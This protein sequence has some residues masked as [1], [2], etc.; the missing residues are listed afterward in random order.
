MASKRRNMFQMNTSQETTENGRNGYVSKASYF[1]ID[2]IENNLIEFWAE[3]NVEVPFRRTGTFRFHPVHQV[4]DA[5][6]RPPGSEVQ[7][8]G[9]GYGESDQGRTGNLLRILQDNKTMVC[10]KSAEEINETIKGKTLYE[11]I[12]WLRHLVYPT[13]APLI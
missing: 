1:T 4:H 6:V 7:E 9:P 10:K 3:F 8:A 13:D 2:H 5:A 11:V 12:D